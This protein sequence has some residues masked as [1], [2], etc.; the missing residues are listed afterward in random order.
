MTNW[1]DYRI[2]LALQREGAA[3]RAA[4]ALRL[5]VSTVRRRLAA[6]EEQLGTRLFH[7]RR[8]GVALTAAGSRL[9]EHARRLEAAAGDIEHE[10]AGAD[11]RLRGTVRLTAGEAFVSL[12]VAPALGAFRARYPEIRVELRSDNQRL[13]LT[14]GEADLAIRLAAPQDDALVGS[15]A[16]QLRFG[17]FASPGYLKARGRPATEAALAG[18]AFIGFDASLERTPETRWL[19]ERG[20]DL[21]VRT[22]SPV[23]IL[24]AAAAGLGIAAVSTLFAGLQGG[25]TRVLPRLALPSREIYLITH[26][27]LR[28]SARVRALQGFLSGLLRERDAA[29]A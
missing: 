13:D 11:Q 23:A 7:R 19:L 15:R 6:L 8:E 17:L 1:D 22:S 18:H 25:L 2:F 29:A 26:Q 20:A 24:S 9:L 3:G 14:R 27:E 4:R 21:V 28:K 5:D 10:V 12:L 16:G